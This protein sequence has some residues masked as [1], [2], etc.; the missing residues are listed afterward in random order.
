M[1][2]NNGLVDS[3]EFT[4]NKDLFNPIDPPPSAMDQ[5]HSG[6][7]TDA[8]PRAAAD[9]ADDTGMGVDTDFDDAEEALFDAISLDDCSDDDNDDDT[10]EDEDQDDEIS[11]VTAVDT[12]TDEMDVDEEVK[13]PRP[14]HEGCK[15]VVPFQAAGCVWTRS[16]WSCAYDVVFMVFFTIYQQSP[17]T[18]RGDW[19]QQSP[20]WTIQLADRFDLLLK[21]SNSLNNSP[22]TL[23]R[24]LVSFDFAPE[25]SQSLGDGVGS[26]FDKSSFVVILHALQK[27]RELSTDLGETCKRPSTCSIPTV[28]K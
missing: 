23:S 24:Y 17:A 2:L 8:S 7:S 15:T 27:S 3:E 20:A 19:K 10:F 18:W 26:N 1:T 25:R 4:N 5:D 16:D 11:E 22:E 9:D 14:P 12:A 13:T 21:A 6:P 28:A